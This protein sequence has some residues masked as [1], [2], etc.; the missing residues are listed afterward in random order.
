LISISVSA[1]SS[2]STSLADSLCGAGDADVV[3]GAAEGIELE[4]NE[5]KE[6]KW[7]EEE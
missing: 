1:S 7:M 6:I 5:R 2:D 3:L 4:K